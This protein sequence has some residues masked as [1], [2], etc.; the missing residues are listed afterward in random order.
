MGEVIGSCC[1]VGKMVYC[2]CS[3]PGMDGNRLVRF[4]AEHLVQENFSSSKFWEEVKL[5][6]GRLP[7]AGQ[8][9]VLM[10]SPNPSELVIL[11]GRLYNEC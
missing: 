1:V 7:W 2:Y 5:T 9:N 4:N 8:T 6:E 10:A 3:N 11:G